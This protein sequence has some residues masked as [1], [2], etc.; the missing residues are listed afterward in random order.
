VIQSTI[1]VIHHDDDFR[2]KITQGL[3][4][5]D[6]KVLHADDLESAM[7]ILSRKH[8]DVVILD[9]VFTKVHNIDLIQKMM[10]DYPC[11]RIIV[12]A[13]HSSLDDAIG[14][15]KSGAVDFIQEPHGYL[16]KPFGTEEIQTAVRKALASPHPWMNREL[17]YERLLDTAV[18]YVKSKDYA[19]AISFARE[20]LRCDPSRPEALTLLGKIEEL[21]GDR[22]NALKKYRAAIDLDPTYQPAHE[23]LH[24]ATTDLHQRPSF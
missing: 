2:S 21:L 19:Q 3:D 7:R 20:S 1:L 5:P 18:D 23:N 6:Y 16:Q 11:L 12:T 8:V 4:I 22:L 15:I 14:V 10:H 17:D 24:R 9:L 13:L